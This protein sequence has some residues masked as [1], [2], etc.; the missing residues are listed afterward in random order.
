MKFVPA[1][2]AGA[3]VIEPQPISDSRGYFSVGWNKNK[4]AEHGLQT[5]FVQINLSGNNHRGTLRG[6]HSRKPGFEEEK[7]IR[8]S[9][10]AA[11]DVIVD[12]RPESD[13]FGQW[14]GVSLTADNGWMMYVPK[15]FL[16][17]YQT[18]EDDTELQYQV[19]RDYEP[20]AEIGARYDDP[21]FNIVWPMPVSEISEKDAAWGPFSIQP[22][23]LSAG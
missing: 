15:G 12:V 8:C 7:L 18:L 5:E 10:G 23:A 14:F 1:P 16:H 21:A 11:F 3:F 2:L 19:G 4:F 17:G 6:L 9:R 22:V 13:T 20:H